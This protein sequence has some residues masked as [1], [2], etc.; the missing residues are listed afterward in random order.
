VS[1][2][3]ATAAQPTKEHFAWVKEQGFEVVVNVS[4]NTARN[5]L[6]DEDV[7]VA[8]AGMQYVHSPVDCSNLQPSHYETLR[9]VLRSLTGKKALVHCAANV[10]A[11]G[12]VHVYRVRELGQD[13]HTLR[14]ALRAQG[15]HEAKWFTY[16]DQMHV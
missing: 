1:P 4:T 13:A 11:S 8:A 14:A 5:F 2:H 16:F 15:W 10:K 6:R 3:L 12:M 7:I 9:D